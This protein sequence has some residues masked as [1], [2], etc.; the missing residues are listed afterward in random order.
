MFIFLIFILGELKDHNS[1]INQEFLS[2]TEIGTQSQSQPEHDA[3][4]ESNNVQENLVINSYNGD[5][6]N[7]DLHELQ[8]NEF[9]D[10]GFQDGN[11]IEPS[12]NNLRNRNSQNYGR[13]NNNNNDNDNNDEEDNEN[14]RMSESYTKYKLKDSPRRQGNQQQ[15]QQQQQQLQQQQQVMVRNNFNKNNHQNFR[16]TSPQR[17]L[18]EMSLRNPK[19]SRNPSEIDLFS[20]N[21]FSGYGGGSRDKNGKWENRE[22]DSSRSSSRNGQQYSHNIESNERMRSNQSQ[23][24]NSNL[25]HRSNNK[26]LKNKNSK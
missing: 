24:P 21:D 19:I 7:Q 18:T 26:N 4:L 3:Q 11:N 10:Y 22:I 23:S 5:D 20:Q 12:R 15:Q 25:S 16:T 9:D 8:N 17:P 1:P 14:D 13:S 6:I 2:T